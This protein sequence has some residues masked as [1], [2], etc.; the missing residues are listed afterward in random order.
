VHDSDVRFVAVLIMLV[1]CS[2]G[3]AR[4]SAKRDAGVTVPPDAPAVIVDLASGKAAYLRLCAPCHGANAKGYAADFSPSL[5]NPTFLESATDDFIH[6]SIVFGRPGTSMGA[7]GKA[8]GG[9]L[10]DA[11]VDG[12]VAWLRSQG[13]KANVLPAVGG[14]DVTKGGAL[15]TEYC[16]TCHGDSMKRGEAPHLANTQWLMNA[17]DSFIRYAIEKGRPETKMPAFGPVM[18]KQQIDDVVA[19]VRTLTQGVPPQQLLPEPTGKE[20]LV[21]NPTGKNPVWQP[22]EGRFIGVDAVAKALKEKRKMIIIDARPP[23]DWRRV[24]V[25]GAVSIPYHD[26]KRLDEIMEKHQDV[27]AIAYCACPHHLS[28]IVA[29]ELTKRGHKKALILDE[30]INLWHQKNYPVTAAE[31]VKPPALEPTPQPFGH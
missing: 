14:G 3:A 30:G 27:Y 28:G 15:Y 20:P 24:H 13:P 9:P 16:K 1:A 5:V 25:E 18:D 26:P 12:V 22:R 19:Y 29:E 31:G 10:T 23:S 7:Y 2:K 6:R 17:T 11:D 8:L 4:T 21:I